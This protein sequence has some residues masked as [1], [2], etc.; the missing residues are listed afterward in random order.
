MFKSGLCLPLV[1]LFLFFG[2]CL[3]DSGDEGFYEFPD[4]DVVEPYTASSNAGKTK[5]ESVVI[6]IPNVGDDHS[7]CRRTKR[8]EN[9]DKGRYKSSSFIKSFLV[10]VDL[11]HKK[12]VN[13]F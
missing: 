5:T 1:Y 12:T 11:N 3:C 13:T 7:Y 2:V 6:D 8:C 10:V 9:V 4:C